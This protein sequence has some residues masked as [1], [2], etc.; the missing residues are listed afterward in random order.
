MKTAKW[1]GRRIKNSDVLV[2]VGVLIEGTNRVTVGM[3]DLV[4]IWLKN[5]S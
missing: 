5:L 1:I 2:K 4:E 3:V